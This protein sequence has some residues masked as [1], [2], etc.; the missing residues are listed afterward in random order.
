MPE[1]KTFKNPTVP[2]TGGREIWIL[3]EGARGATERFNMDD[4]D[5]EITFT[6]KV[7]PIPDGTLVESTLGGAKYIKIDGTWY[8]LNA[9]SPDLAIATK[10]DDEYY[11]FQAL[12]LAKSTW[13]D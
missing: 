1:K 3:P 10:Q 6:K 9:V 12:P 4:W 11:R 2:T 5:V 8:F 13:E 7:K